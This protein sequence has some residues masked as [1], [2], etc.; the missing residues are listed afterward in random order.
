MR[1]DTGTGDRREGPSQP[2]S[3]SFRT[4][5]RQAWRGFRGTEARSLPHRRAWPHAL[6]RR[7]ADRV[8][9]AGA[10]W[11]IRVVPLGIVAIVPGR[12][13]RLDIDLGEWSDDDR[14]GVI[15]RPVR[16]PVRPDGHSEA[17]P[18]EAMA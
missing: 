3:A 16:T 17:R 6:G 13:G 9:P 4:G 12:R 2:P 1:T 8:P 7:R 15:R 5:R 14:R 10:L 11:H 18:D